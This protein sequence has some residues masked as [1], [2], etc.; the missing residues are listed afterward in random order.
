MKD[1]VERFKNA[2]EKKRLSHLYLLSGSAG[3]TKKKIVRE[4]AYEIFK[5][6]NDYP[7]LR[8]QLD[9]ENHPN[10]VYIAKDGQSI[11]KEQVIAL[12]K[13]FSKTSLVAGYRV[14]I[15]EAAE[16]MSNAAANSLLKF[17]EEPKD[18]ETI[19]FLL[20][21]DLNAIIPTILSRAQVILI[22]DDSEQDF[23]ESLTKNEI[24]EADAYYLSTLTKDFEEA[25][26][27]F[28][29][30]QYQKSVESFKGLMQWF[31]NS[32]IPLS[33]LINDLER[34]FSADKNWISF[35][36][37]LVSTMMLDVIHTHMH[38]KNI[39][40]FMNETVLALVRNISVIKAEKVIRIL[41]ETIKHLRLPVNI[42]MTMQSF[43]IQIEEIFKDGRP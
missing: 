32:D 33:M 23:I 40:E 12:Q 21:D 18:N 28:D 22:E 26:A 42:S 35:I 34:N 20:T 14:Y 7:S 25:N 8:Q 15:I 11:K 24:S 17:L 38:Q 4:L 13:E 37:N 41:H 43:A 36:L 1:I 30:P 39:F 16:T 29:D 9:N 27:F 3:I 5:S 2:I 31:S 19:G 10:L 6:F